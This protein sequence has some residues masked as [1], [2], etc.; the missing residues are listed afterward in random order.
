MG[1][2]K[3]PTHYT[4]LRDCRLVLA[5]RS[6]M[7]PNASQAARMLLDRRHGCSRHQGAVSGWA[8]PPTPMNPSLRP[9]E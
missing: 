1:A 5:V 6:Q 4:S 7:S 9:G 8:G 2:Q 3:C